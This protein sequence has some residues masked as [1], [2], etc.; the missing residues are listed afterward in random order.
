VVNVSKSTDGTTVNLQ[1][2]DGR[3]IDA[4]KVTQWD[5]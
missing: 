2:A 4:S 5:T 3:I 1:L